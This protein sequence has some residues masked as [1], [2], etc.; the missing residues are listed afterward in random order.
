[1]VCVVLDSVHL[2]GP[3]KAQE[4]VG[5]EPGQ[6][7][8]GA[9]PDPDV[10]PGQQGLL[11]EDRPDRRERKRGH[12][13]W[14][15]AGCG[16][17]LVPGGD[18]RR[19]SSERPGDLG[20]VGMPV[21]RDEDDD[22]AAVADEDEGL[23]DLARVDS[24]RLGHIPDS[25]DLLGELLEPG[26]GPRRTE[27]V[28]YALHGLGEHARNRIGSFLVVSEMNAGLVRKATTEAIFRHVNE[29][30]AESAERFDADEAEFV[31]ECGD[32][33]CTHRLEAQ[34]D[35]Y[36][37]VRAEPTR[38]LLAPGHED[39]AIEKV[40]ERCGRFEVV[41]KFERTVV[42]TVRSLNPRKPKP[43]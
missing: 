2:S 39:E 5:G 29:R 21:A 17:N 28:G 8:L 32:R 35:D 1:M 37:R 38:F 31:C 33:S 40:V 24:E 11:Q 13:A 4:L 27:K 36:E 22:G 6:V 15:K 9:R 30:I 7:A 20:A 18:P 12:G 10:V 34:L 3:G 14:R 23:D 41:E 42:A 43:A 19:P 25:R 16:Q 26:L